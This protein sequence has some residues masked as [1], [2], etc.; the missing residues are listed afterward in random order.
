MRALA[1][2]NGDPD[3]SA[4]DGPNGP[5]ARPESGSPVAE[6]VFFD[7]PGVLPLSLLVGESRIADNGAGGLIVNGGGSVQAIL[8]IEAANG[9]FRYFLSNPDPAATL[10]YYTPERETIGPGGAQQIYE[11]YTLLIAGVTVRL[12]RAAPTV[13]PVLI[14]PPE[15]I[16]VRTVQDGGV[17]AG[18]PPANPELF[19]PN[20][21]SGPV[22]GEQGQRVNWRARRPAHP[23]PFAGDVYPDD[24]PPVLPPDRNAP[25]RYLAMLPA[26]FQD[27]DHDSHFLRRFLLLLETLWE[28]LEMRQDH[29]ALYFSPWTCPVSFL[30]FLASWI[31]LDVRDMDGLPEGTRRRYIAEAL[32]IPARAGANAPPTPD[33]LTDRESD[34]QRTRQPRRTAEQMRHYG[35]LR[36]RGT[37]HGLEDI[38]SLSL[39][40]T[41][42]VRTDEMRP[43][44]FTVSVEGNVEPGGM[45]AAQRA[46][47]ILVERH[48]PAVMDWDFGEWRMVE[49]HSAL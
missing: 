14:V 36:R 22:P 10:T 11:R 15:T 48:K 45:E 31:G 27:G 23:I 18:S 30:P 28:P 6:L 33:G 3:D 25:S 13:T 32:G 2:L 37:L 42:S 44:F 16:P 46:I 29:L 9:D 38:L 20:N 24:P 39:G 40:Y 4:G 34:G 49:R 43:F 21:P 47:E 19:G 1:S 26:P 8:Y 35:W 41:F 7:Q 5:V 12:Q 17:A